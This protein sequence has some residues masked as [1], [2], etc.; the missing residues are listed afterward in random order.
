[1][2]TGYHNFC[3]RKAVHI[4]FVAWSI[5]HAMRMRHIVS[6]GLPAS[7]IFFPHYLINGAIFERK[8]NYWAWNLC[9]DFVCTI[10]LKHFSFVEKLNEMWSKMCTGLHVKCPLFLSDFNETVMKI[11]WTDFRKIL[12]S[13]FIK[14]LPVGAEFFHA[15]RRTDII[16]NICNFTNMPKNQSV[17]A[18]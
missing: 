13:N 6:C 12:I 4:P 18:V 3:G 9:F 7:K 14:I 10:C 1:M 15:D 8:K 16:V 5:Q 17:N 11:F 2:R